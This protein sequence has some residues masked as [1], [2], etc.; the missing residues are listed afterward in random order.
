MLCVVACH[1]VACPEHVK[2][3]VAALQCGANLAGQA[4]CVYVCELVCS[5]RRVCVCVCARA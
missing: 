2:A 4:A 1:S 3:I 5:Q